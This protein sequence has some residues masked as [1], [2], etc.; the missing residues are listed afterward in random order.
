[1]YQN[2]PCYLENCVVREPCKQRTACINVA[3]KALRDIHVGCQKIAIYYVFQLKFRDLM[4]SL[5]NL[6]IFFKRTVHIGKIC[7]NI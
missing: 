6:T 1:M 3:L 5:A 2:K 7:R 4:T